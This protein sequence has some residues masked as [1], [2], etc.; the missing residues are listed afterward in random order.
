MVQQ[1]IHQRSAIA[2]VVGSSSPGVHHHPGRLVNDRQVLIFV[3]DIE[4]DLL[5][6]GAQGRTCSRTEYA[7]ALASPQ[8]QRSL[9]WS[10]VE[11]NLLGLKKFLHASAA[12]LEARD[13]EL[14][15]TLACVA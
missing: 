6:Y 12:N 15:Q 9:S 2:C 3:H 4:W 11:Q 10:V 1:R 5:G 14:V 7:H 8:F 13:E